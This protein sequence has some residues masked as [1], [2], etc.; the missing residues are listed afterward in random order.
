MQTYRLVSELLS[1]VIIDRL[2]LCILY[3][4]THAIIYML[5]IE[6]RREISIV[7]IIS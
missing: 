4:Y 5:T 3:E 7:N 1:H 2:Y 6:R